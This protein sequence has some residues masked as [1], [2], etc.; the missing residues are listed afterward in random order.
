[1]I[2][3]KLK[4][5]KPAVVIKV[6]SVYFAP[7]TANARKKVNFMINQEILEVLKKWIPA[8][9]RSNFVNGALEEAVKRYTKEKAFQMIDEL[10]AKAK[11][12]MSTAEMIKLKNYGRE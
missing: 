11:L 6:K 4:K 9:D 5:R 12:R 10:R 1:M 8:G 7:K 3:S 2:T